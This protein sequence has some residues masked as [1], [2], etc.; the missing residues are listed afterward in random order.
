[1]SPF[2]LLK[3]FACLLCFGCTLILT[4]VAQTFQESEVQPI[5]LPSSSLTNIETTLIEELI[6]G[7]V[8]RETL[9]KSMEFTLRTLEL[10]NWDHQSFPPANASARFDSR[11]AP[12]CFID[13]LVFPA[14]RIG[15]RLDQNLID[16]LTAGLRL[17]HARQNLTWITDPAQAQP[18]GY[19][20][21]LLGS[22]SFLIE[23]QFINAD[24]EQ[25]HVRQFLMSWNSF[26]IAAKFLGTGEHTTTLSKTLDMFV[27]NLSIQ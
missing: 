17:R 22:P 4:T 5:S 21:H 12:G 24:H 16:R 14:S 18:P 26:I 1:M 20:G 23:Y 10:R 9:M 8:S 19:M 11:H 3:R 6:D 13:L 15:E 2:N 27:H 7:L 25:I